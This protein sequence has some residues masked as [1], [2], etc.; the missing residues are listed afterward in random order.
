METTIM[1]YFGS[2]YLTIMGLPT[3]RIIVLRGLYQG[4]LIL[5]NYQK[6]PLRDG[7]GNGNYWVI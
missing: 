2:L 7:K 1:A 4:P 5:V 3:I 6:N